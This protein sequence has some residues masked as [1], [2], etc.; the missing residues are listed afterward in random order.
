MPIGR[1]PSPG[2]RG[3]QYP[4]WG[5]RLRKKES[6]EQNFAGVVQYA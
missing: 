1:V 2:A 5:Q 3:V 6:F 4:S